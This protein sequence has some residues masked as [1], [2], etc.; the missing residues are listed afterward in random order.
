MSN[1][2]LR[3]ACGFSFAAALATTPFMVQAND[4]DGWASLEEAHESI[5]KADALIEHADKLVEAADQTVESA[6]GAIEAIDLIVEDA[7]AAFADDKTYCR[8]LMAHA[9]AAIEA[10]ASDTDPSGPEILGIL[11]G[12]DLLV[13]AIDPLVHDSRNHV[14]AAALALSGARGVLRRALSNAVDAAYGAD[15]AIEAADAMVEASIAQTQ[16]ADQAVEA[17]KNCDSA[18]DL[19]LADDEVEAADGA[20]E[21]ADGAVE[22]A[23]KAIELADR[24]IERADRLIERAGRGRRR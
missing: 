22:A 3:F 9:D 4:Q 24:M 18:D 19:Q 5:E 23:D 2:A 6:D 21:A 13:E 17:A 15:V 16:K 1:K 10:L 8:A 14:E 7:I 20:I 11:G 12:A